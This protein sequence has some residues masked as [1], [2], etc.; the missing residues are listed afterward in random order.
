M[1][2]T[3]VNTSKINVETGIKIG[4]NEASVKVVEFINLRCPFCRQWFEE[5]N[6]LLQQL[7][8]EGK[9][10]RIIKLFDKEK[11]SL[12]VGNIMQH[13]VPNN[14]SALAAIHAIYDTQDEWSGL[15]THEDVANY[16]TE[17]LQLT[18]QDYKK[19]ADFIIQ[20]AI[21]ANVFFV[22]TIIIGEHVVDQKISNEELLNLIEE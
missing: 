15:D 21:D 9:I 17:K 20:E 11:P 14:D 2:M 3:E 16:A 5:K 13:H 10:Q 22:P 6:D 12:A 4:S 7:V 1:G 8:T 19:E 18:L